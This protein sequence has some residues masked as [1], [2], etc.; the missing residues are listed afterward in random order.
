M[1]SSEKKKRRVRF[2]DTP[3][4]CEFP[5]DAAQDKGQ[6]GAPAS[7]RRHLDPMEALEGE[8]A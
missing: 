7:K 4:I 2:S 5:S 3:T 6:E 8:T 1:S